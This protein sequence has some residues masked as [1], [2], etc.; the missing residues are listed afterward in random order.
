MRLEDC[1]LDLSV[2]VMAP[3]SRRKP[4]DDWLKAKKSGAIPVSVFALYTRANYLSFGGAPPFLRD[5]E[6]VLFSYFGMVLGSVMKSLVEAEEEQRLF[7]KAHG[8]VYDPLKRARGQEWD[9][10]ADD[11]ARR[12][13]RYL[14]LSAGCLGRL[15]G[16]GRAVPY[17]ARAKVTC[18]ASKVFSA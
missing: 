18:R 16:H 14:L 1:E 4:E 2:A 3:I 17:W 13:F 11:R 10:S 9:P 8:E 5:D 15:C 7:V 6:N 12:H